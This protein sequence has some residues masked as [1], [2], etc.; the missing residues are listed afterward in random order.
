MRRHTAAITVPWVMHW[1]ATSRERLLPNVVAMLLIARSA[2]VLNAV[3]VVARHVEELGFRMG[4]PLCFLK[5]EPR[6]S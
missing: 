1:R 6:S 2:D 5:G 4:K 3:W